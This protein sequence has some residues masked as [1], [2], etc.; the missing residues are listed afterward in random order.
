M[1]A[2]IIKSLRIH[3]VPHCSR[4]NARSFH[5]NYSCSRIRLSSSFTHC[6][7][8]LALGVAIPGGIGEND[9]VFGGE[10]VGGFSGKRERHRSFD[11][12][13]ALTAHDSSTGSSQ[14]LGGRW[15]FS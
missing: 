10:V 4:P 15:A 11:G 5:A 3:E 1:A 6:Q 8:S 12:G 13:S 9:K 2:T 14:L 7:C